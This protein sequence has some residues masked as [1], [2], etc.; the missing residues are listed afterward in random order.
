M[1]L[2]K[3]LAAA[4]L[5]AVL[6]LSMV[7][8]GKAEV[9]AAYKTELTNMLKDSL[10]GTEAT[11]ENTTELDNA[12][13]VLLA[14]AQTE[15]DK[16][17]AEQK[18]AVGDRQITDWLTAETAVAKATGLKEKYCFVSFVE[19][20]N[21]VSNFGSQF[22]YLEMMQKLQ[23]DYRNGQIVLEDNQAVVGDVAN[24]NTS[25]DAKVGFASGKLGDKT[26]VVMVM[27]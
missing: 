23:P 16:L 25:K 15:Y 24:K 27:F 26:Y 5:A 11:V 17:T 8:C 1:K 13:Q 20:P 10:Y 12:A 14:N 19:N 4:A 22:K 2:F 21:F 9:G 3:K 7:G 6:A 18:K